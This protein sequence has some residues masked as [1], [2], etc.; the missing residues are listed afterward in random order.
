MGIN[1]DLWDFPHPM[2]LKVM[3]AASA[4]L[5]D[6]VSRILAHHLDNFDASTQLGQRRKSSKGT[7]VSLTANI[8]M[9]NKTQVE[10]IYAE[11]KQ[12]PDIKAV[13]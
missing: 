7:Y 12:H 4:P 5:T 9:Q 13:L 8:V 11:L 6:I 3:G 1:E 2:R 10:A